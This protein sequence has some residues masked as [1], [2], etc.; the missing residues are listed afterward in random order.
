MLVLEQLS[1]SRVFW[2]RDTQFVGEDPKVL[3]VM[4]ILGRRIE[5]FSF[6]L[7]PGRYSGMVCDSHEK[8]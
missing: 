1:S 2:A 5:N 8:Q 4:R 3:E 6:L 7:M